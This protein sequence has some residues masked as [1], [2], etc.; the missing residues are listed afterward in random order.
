M[1]KKN[2]QEGEKELKQEGEIIV[3]EIKS[4]SYFIKIYDPYNNSNV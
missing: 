2:C 1:K 4:K 3:N